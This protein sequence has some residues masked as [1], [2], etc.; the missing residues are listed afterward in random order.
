MNKKYLTLGSH[1]REEL[2]E[3][4]II[5]Q[6]AKKAWSLALTKDDSLYLDS[7]ALNL[8]DFYSGL[9]RIFERVAENIDETKPESLNWHQQILKQMAMEIPKVRPAVISQDLKEELDKYRAFRHIVRNIYAHNFRIDK[10]K[11]L[12]GNIDKVLSELE[13]ELRIFYEFLENS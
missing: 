5:I 10:M 8:H 12:M 11:D 13:K 3:I 6:R 7:V 1:I 2:S 9:E 4:Q